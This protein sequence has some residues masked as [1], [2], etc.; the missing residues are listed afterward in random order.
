M[1]SKRW[2]LPERSPD[3]CVELA[4]ALGVSPILAHLLLSRG[5][6]SEVAAR[7]FLEPS[8]DHL[9][10]PFLLPDARPA[11]ERIVRAIRDGERILVHGD[12]DV[13]GVCAAALL[14]RVLRVLKANVEPFTP[15]RRVD[16]YDL[17]VE[18]VHRSADEGVRL[19]VTADCGIVAFEAARAAKERGVDL[20]ITDHHEPD[21]NGGLPEA[22]A[23]VNPKRPGS[24][25]PFHELCGTGV[26]FKLACAL[27]QELGISSSKFRTG[28][29]D[30][31][32]LATCADCMPLVDENRI[33]VKWGLET[34]R[35]TNKAGLQALMKVAGLPPHLASARSMGFVLGPRINAIG[36]LDASA[37]ALKLLL[38]SDTAEA[39]AL[40]E[41]L[42]QANRERQQEQERIL[43]EAMRQAERF[44]EDRILVL[45]ST[46]WHPGVIG[47][48]A[49]KITESLC[50]PTVMVALDEEAGSGRGSCRSV[51]GFDIFGAVNTCREHLVRCG[52]HQAAAGFDIR[53]ASLEPF[54]VALQEFAAHSLEEEL[55]Q[56]TVRVDVEVAPERLTRQLVEEL[57]LLEPYGHGNHEPVFVTRGLSVLEQR[58]LSNKAANAMDHLKLRLDTPSTRGGVDAL[59]WRAWPRSVECA[60]HSRIDAC[61]TLEINH[62]NGYKNLQM[63]LKDLR[64]C[65]A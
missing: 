44:L 62:Y 23:V 5:A 50:R 7:R 37:H 56:P 21:P 24:E 45:S 22:L 47:I 6:A 30:L 26:A 42:D 46:N 2:L 61:Y 15:H 19:I 49:S 39:D 28:Y 57:S 64:A 12:Y 31:V 14:T 43:T 10:D 1:A 48:V 17:Q 33:F 36:R 55:L 59:F 65:E 27:V 41:R 40:A 53:P 25:Y 4:A 11:V 32:A 51:E 54:R 38:T 52:G 3:D 9:H 18:T 35:A 63:V 13:D 8:L 29:L 34:L 58:R 16:G 60:P 20:I